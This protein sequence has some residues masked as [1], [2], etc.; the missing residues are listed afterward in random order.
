MPIPIFEYNETLEDCSPSNP[1]SAMRLPYRE[2]SNDRMARVAGAGG[3]G[4]NHWGWCGGC[5]GNKTIGMRNWS[6][7]RAGRW[8]FWFLA[9]PSENVG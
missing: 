3:S 8:V 7:R 9:M 6:R 2:A 5:P 1:G 4:S